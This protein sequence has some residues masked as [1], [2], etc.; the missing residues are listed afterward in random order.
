[1]CGVCGV[2]GLLCGE[3]VWMWSIPVRSCCASACC[4]YSTPAKVATLQA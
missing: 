2:E 3:G 4:W 1:M